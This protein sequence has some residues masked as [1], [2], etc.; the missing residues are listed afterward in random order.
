MSTWTCTNKA[1]KD[2]QTVFEAAPGVTGTPECSTCGAWLMSEANMVNHKAQEEAKAKHDQAEED[3]THEL[4]R[5]EI[6][7]DQQAEEAK[8]KGEAF[9]VTQMLKTRAP[10]GSGKAR[11]Q[12]EEQLAEALRTDREWIYLGLA[13][14]ADKQTLAEQDQH[15]SNETNGV[16]FT[17]FDADILTSFADQL[18][19]RGSLSPKQDA[20]LFKRMPKYAGQ[21]LRLKKAG[22]SGG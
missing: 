21:I 15:Q 19:Y 7:R 4:Q 17:K 14:I 5:L 11:K 18:K 22:G 12:L 9:S 13:L 8:L 1:C 3:G 2:Y 16:G 10:R 20:I 6:E